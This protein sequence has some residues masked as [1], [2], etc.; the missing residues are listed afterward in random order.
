MKI[1]FLTLGFGLFSVVTVNFLVDPAHRWHRAWSSF[2]RNWEDEQVWVSA[3]QFNERKF[4][5]EH[6]RVIEP[7]DILIMGSSRAMT[8]KSEHFPGRRVYN[9]ALSGAS[10]EDHVALWQGFKEAGKLPKRVL[11]YLDTWNLNQNTFAR[12]R[13]ITNFSWL[14]RFYHERLSTEPLARTLWIATLEQYAMGRFSEMVDMASVTLLRQS[15]FSL[16]RPNWSNPRDHQVVARTEQ[17]DH[18]EAWARDGSLVHSR[19]ELNDRSPASV[20]QI[21]RDVKN[22]AANAYLGNWDFDGNAESALKL[23]LQDASTSGIEVKIVIP[24]F[25]PDTFK[26]LSTR[27]EYRKVLPEFNAAIRKL[28]VETCDMTDPSVA[29]CSEDEFFD[30]AHVDAICTKKILERCRIS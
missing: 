9:T 16:F 28:P 10:I 4:R 18:R 21:A 12:H 11:L 15:L 1:F 26:I 17:P 5:A 29:D 7:P 3:P 14:E 13:W 27:P 6:L 20:R 8:V 19:N 2:E 23:M 24:P 30:S 22:G 25:H